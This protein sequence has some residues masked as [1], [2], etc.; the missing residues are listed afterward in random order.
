MQPVLERPSGRRSAESVA[1][2]LQSSVIDGEL[3][4]IIQVDLQ[5]KR[6]QRMYSA[7]KDVALTVSA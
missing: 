6:T 3:P 1:T 2:P 4:A 5:S 7:R